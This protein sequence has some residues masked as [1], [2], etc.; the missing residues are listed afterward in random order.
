MKIKFNLILK[1]VLAIVAVFTFMSAG[2]QQIRPAANITGPLRVKSGS[3]N[4]TITSQMVA[5]ANATT[6]Y[7][8]SDNSSGAT[9]VSK[10]NLVYNSSTGIS[11]QTV[12]VNPGTSKG[13]FNIQLVVTSGGLSAESSKSVTIVK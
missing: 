10:G 4:V 12:V 6:T 7:T 11:T 1:G 8:L 9:I 3:G 2:A 5:D 13:S